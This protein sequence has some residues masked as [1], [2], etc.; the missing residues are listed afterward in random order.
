VNDA[1][2]RILF[3]DDRPVAERDAPVGHSDRE[4]AM[5]TPREIIEEFFLGSF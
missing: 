3:G 4:R 1:N 2:L 5:P